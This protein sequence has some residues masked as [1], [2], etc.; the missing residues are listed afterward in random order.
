MKLREKLERKVLEYLRK[1]YPVY[2]YDAIKVTREMVDPEVFTATAE[3][4][5]DMWCQCHDDMEHYLVNSA[6]Y[7]IAQQI[8]EKHFYKAI[9]HRDI[10]RMRIV[11]KV[12]VKVLPIEEHCAGK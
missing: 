7:S 12:F 3:C 6:L 11:K 9:E 4:D 10:P 5:A 2:K 8:S 1:K